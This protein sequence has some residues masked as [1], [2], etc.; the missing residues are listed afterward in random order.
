MRNIVTVDGIRAIKGP[1]GTPFL[2]GGQDQE[3][4]LLWCLSVDFFN[5]YYNKIA[6][7]VASVGYIIL[8]C[9][10]LPLN[11]WN[12][13]ENMCLIGIIPWPRELFRGKIDH[14]LCPLIKIMKESWAEGAIYKMHE[15]PHGRLV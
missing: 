11:M 12:R 2:A 1:D 14:F 5:P 3:L 13:P 15:Y 10:L 8:S 6:G 9:L 4:C 7:K